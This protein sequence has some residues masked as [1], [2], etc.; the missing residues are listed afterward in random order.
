MSHCYPCS[1]AGTECW[2]EG[3]CAW[4]CDDLSGG[5]A[6]CFGCTVYRVTYCEQHDAN[7]DCYLVQYMSPVGCNYVRC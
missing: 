7:G 3:G 2:C 6:T 1:D 5:T 4:S